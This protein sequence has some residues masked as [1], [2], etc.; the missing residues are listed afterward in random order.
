MHMVVQD[1][2]VRVTNQEGDEPEDGPP[3]G[4]GGRAARA[5]GVSAQRGP[6]VSDEVRWAWCKRL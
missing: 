5:S 6:V 4:D 3:G 2:T 1:A